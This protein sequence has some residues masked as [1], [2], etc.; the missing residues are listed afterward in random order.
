[1]TGKTVT[2]N[3][4]YAAAGKTVTLLVEKAN[5]DV[6]YR[7]VIANSKG[8]ITKTFKGATKVVTAFWGK[9]YTNTVT[10]K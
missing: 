9:S 7:S 2:A 3:F 10:V 8:V 4:G 6:L 1:M 5:G